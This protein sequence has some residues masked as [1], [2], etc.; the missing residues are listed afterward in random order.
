MQQNQGGRF[1]LCLIENM[2]SNHPPPPDLH[3][4]QN[5]SGTDRGGEGGSCDSTPHPLPPPP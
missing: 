4:V 3:L 5:C 1:S 2:T